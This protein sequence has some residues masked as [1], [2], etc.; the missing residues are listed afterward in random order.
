VILDNTKVVEGLEMFVVVKVHDFSSGELGV[1]NFRCSLSGFELALY[2][3]GPFLFLT[4]ITI[5]SDFTNN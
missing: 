5:E 2:S 1:V 3:S 4:L